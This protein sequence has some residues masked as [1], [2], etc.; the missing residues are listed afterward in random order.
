M[1]RQRL[2]AWHERQLHA[3]PRLFKSARWLACRLVRRQER[4][5]SLW[6][7]CRLV[8][9]LEHQRSLWLACRLVRRPAP[10]IGHWW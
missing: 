5:R 1:Q 6:L 8:R 4:H 2:L 9:R 3:R 7:A 10:R